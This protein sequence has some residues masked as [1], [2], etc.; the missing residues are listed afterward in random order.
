MMLV[1]ACIVASHWR[2]QHLNYKIWNL[3]CELRF[4]ERYNSKQKGSTLCYINI[5]TPK[6]LFLSIIFQFLRNLSNTSFLKGL[7]KMIIIII[8]LFINIFIYSFIPGQK[9][10]INYNNTY[11]TYL[12]SKIKYKS[13]L[14]LFLTE[15][16]K[17]VIVI[18]SILNM[19]LISLM[20][21]GKK[22]QYLNKPTTK[23]CWLV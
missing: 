16:I 19:L 17:S 23:S 13:K 20:F 7:D 14:E 5:L 15:R 6:K 9:L 2:Q 18:Y 4:S 11:Y 22:R 8:Y 12:S 1:A 21:N 10:K 3:K